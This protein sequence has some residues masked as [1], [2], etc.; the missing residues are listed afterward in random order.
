MTRLRTLNPQGGAA[1]LEAVELSR[2]LLHAARTL[3]GDRARAELD[4]LA[5]Q[6]HGLRPERLEGDACRIAFW[7]NV[8][9]ALIL[10]CLARRP[11]R[12]SLLRHL[13]LFDRVAYRVGG[14]VYPLNLI[15][16]G[17]LR[18]NARPPYRPR[19]LLRSGDPRLAAAPTRLDARIHFAL[20][21]GAASCPP[22]RSYEASGLEQQ[23]ELATRSYLGAES[24]L[25][26]D[27]ARLS[28]PRLMRLYRVDFGSREAQ[29]GL[30]ARHVPGVEDC[31][32][33]TASR[34]RVDY[35]RFDWTVAGQAG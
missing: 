25:D 26:Q 35:G 14:H 5:A 20:N 28:L 34:L 16:H 9:N 2:E 10:D 21:C 6:L 22:I 33:S 32:R 7:A 4:Q 27:C 19:R 30:A 23:L 17:L 1:R 13:R 18:R 29:L 8:Y 3:D 12:G 31:L 11:L 15:E 24:R